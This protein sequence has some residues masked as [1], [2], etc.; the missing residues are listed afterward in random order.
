MLINRYRKSLSKMVVCSKDRQKEGRLMA[1]VFY[2]Y[3]MVQS[4]RGPLKKESQTVMVRS[5]GHQTMVT[6]TKGIG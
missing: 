1:M 5:L 6:F 2:N 4:S 3:Q